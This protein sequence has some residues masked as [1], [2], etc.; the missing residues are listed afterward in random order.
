[1][2][3]I[4]VD[5]STRY[6][7]LELKN[8]LVPSASPLSKDLDLARRLEDAGASAIVMYSLFE[9]QVARDEEA[10]AALLNQDI[11][12]GEADSY[13]PAPGENFESTLD[14]YLAQLGALKQSLDIPVIA[15]L[16]AVSLSGWVDHAIELEQTGADALELN[17]YYVAADIDESGAD[18]ENRY[19]EL[20]TELKRHV[21]IPIS[22]KLS[23][24]FSSPGNLVKRLAAAGADGVVLF[25][26]FYQPDI[27][28]HTLAVDPALHLSR[29]ADALLA[30]HWI[31]ILHGRVDI[32][33]AATGG[34]HGHREAIKMLLAGAD[35]TQLCASL[36]NHGPE[37]LGDVLSGIRTWMEEN[38]YESVEQLKGS[39]SHRH[40]G[41]PAGYERLNYVDLLSSQ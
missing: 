26:R 38:E 32:S 6:L 33:L 7:G 30:M 28:L 4:T 27:D 3:G 18:V 41:D 16:N 1:M 25:N 11:G 19:V 15:S 23:P 29:P 22:M 12:H 31:A 8:P 39:V 9:E 2:S 17:V 21:N 34:V 14:T 37:H 10:F 24:Q 20:L 13:L 35:V 5:L 40:A 36:L